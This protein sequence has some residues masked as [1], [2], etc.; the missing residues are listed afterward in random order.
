MVPGLPPDANPCCVAVCF[1][2]SGDSGEEEMREGWIAEVP[3]GIVKPVPRAVGNWVWCKLLAGR[4]V[5]SSTGL[6]L[7][8]GPLPHLRRCLPI[9]GAQ[10]DMYA[11]VLDV[12]K[13]HRW[14]KICPEEQSL[15]CFH[16]RDR[17][18]KCQIIN[19]G[20]KA[21]NKTPGPDGCRA[22]VMKLLTNENRMLALYNDILHNSVD[23][24]SCKN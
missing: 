22:E 21:S 23:P 24:Q 17:L 12:A 6:C 8:H 9:G 13:A 19:L 20:A 10:E 3:G 14:I 11:L 7:E 2:P 16:H 15:L 4:R 1:L 18:F 5:W